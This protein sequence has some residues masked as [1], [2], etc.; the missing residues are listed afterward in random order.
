MIDKRVKINIPEEKLLKYRELG[1]IDKVLDELFKMADLAEYEF[2]IY[3]KLN[4]DQRP[5]KLEPSSKKQIVFFVCDESDVLPSDDELD[6]TFLAFRHYLPYKSYKDKLYYLPVGYSRK[7]SDLPIIPINERPINVFFSGNLHLGRAKLYRYFSKFSFLPFAA[8]HRLQ[9][10]LKGNFGH[11][12]PASHIQFNSGFHSGLS[13]EEYNKQIY[14]SKILLCPPGLN[15][16]ETMRHFEALK[17]GSIIISEKMP[18]VHTYTN[19]PMI[20]VDNWKEIETII[21]DLLANPAKMENLHQ[22]T[23]DWWQQVSSEKGTAAYIY[24]LI[25]EKEKR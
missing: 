18:D 1:Y 24:N 20:F 23:K 21:P 15:Q 2:Y 9:K 13:P 19:S 12:F 4:N 17:A 5:I 16:L 11:R 3:F 6:K 7:F 25:L 8:L 22:A 10:Y 14:K